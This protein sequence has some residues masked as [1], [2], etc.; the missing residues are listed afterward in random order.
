MVG[1]RTLY[2]LLYDLYVQAGW[3]DFPETI[4][5]RRDVY[6]ILHRLTV[7]GWVNKGYEVQFGLSGPHPFGDSAFVSR[8]ASNGPESA[9]LRRQVFNTFRDP[10]GDNPSQLPWAWIYGDAMEVPAGDSPRQ[11]AAVSP[12]QYRVLK[13]WAAGTFESDWDQP[14]QPPRDLSGVPVAEQP[15][16]LDRAALEYGLADA[17]HPGCE[18]TWPI[19][20][21]TMWKAPFRLKHRPEGVP[22][23]DYGPE[24]TQKIALSAYGPLYAQGPGDL[25]RWMGLPWQ[26]D[27][28]FCRSGYDTAYDTAYDPYIPTFWPATVPNQ[29]LTTEA[30]E[31][32]MKATTPEQRAAAFAQRFSWVRPLDPDGQASISDEMKKMVAIFGRAP[33]SGRGPA[34]PAAPAGRLVR[35]RDRAAQRREG[36]GR[37]RGG[38]ARGGGE[39]ESFRGPRRRA[40]GAEGAG[41]E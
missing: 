39:T 10:E 17:F 18:V 23:P 3:L 21:L 12:T 36:G 14:G 16:T 1:V 35:A 7:L 8:L 15:A 27:T 31:A 9:E 26:A 5:F 2:D 25:T 13:L 6:P 20:H 11:N 40:G 34:R 24:L 33:R 32:V 4:S 37:G 30:Y 41:R 28:A 38:G 22:P 29:V 19:R